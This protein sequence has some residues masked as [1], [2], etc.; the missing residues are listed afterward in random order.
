MGY[1]STIESEVCIRSDMFLKFVK[2]WN[3]R[4]DEFLYFRDLSFD[5]SFYSKHEKWPVKISF[6]NNSGKRYGSLK[7]AKFLAKYADKCDLIFYGEDD[8]KWGF[9]FNGKGGIFG[10]Q[11]ILQFIEVH[12][13]HL[14]MP[15]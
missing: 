11:P 1:N 3:K 8:I 9:R 14:N 5:E 7:F 13:D 10:L 12:A 4:R 6:N 15:C 2:D